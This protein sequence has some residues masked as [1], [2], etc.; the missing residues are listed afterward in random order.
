MLLA[1]SSAAPLA[2]WM[3][4]RCRLLLPPA[5]LQRCSDC[6]LLVQT[7]MQRMNLAAPRCTSLM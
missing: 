5:K 3:A 1:T 4:P 6:W 7:L 2:A